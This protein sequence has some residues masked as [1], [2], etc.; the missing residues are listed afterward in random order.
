[1]EIAHFDDDDS[2]TNRGWWSTRRTRASATLG[3]WH[4]LWGPEADSDWEVSVLVT[5]SPAGMSAN[6]AAVGRRSSANG[7]LHARLGISPH[8]KLIFFD[9]PWFMAE[10]A[11]PI[12]AELAKIRAG[13]DFHFVATVEDDHVDAF[14]EAYERR[15]WNSIHPR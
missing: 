5:D 9:V 12:A 11:A 2:G 14:R 15:P 13:E 10:S 3:S 4:N 8:K 1:M 7:D 6:P